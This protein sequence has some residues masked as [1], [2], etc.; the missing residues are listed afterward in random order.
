LRKPNIFI[1]NPDMDSIPATQ[2]LIY[3]NLRFLIFPIFI[4]PQKP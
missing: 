3:D 4:L 1:L 2:R